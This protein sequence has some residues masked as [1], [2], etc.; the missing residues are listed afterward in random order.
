MAEPTSFFAPPEPQSS[1]SG[2]TPSDPISAAVEAVLVKLFP[3]GDGANAGNIA[4]LRRARAEEF[5]KALPADSKELLE[6]RAKW[7]D[8]EPKVGRF[9]DLEKLYATVAYKETP[10]WKE[11]FEKPLSAAKAEIGE[12]AKEY[13]I[14][15]KEIAA[16]EAMTPK[17]RRAK[18]EKEHGVSLASDMERSFRE[19]ARASK[20]AADEAARLGGEG[21]DVQALLKAVHKH[22]ATAADPGKHVEE[23]ASKLTAKDPKTGLPMDPFFGSKEGQ[24]VIGALKGKPVSTEPADVAALALKGAAYDRIVGEYAKLYA[25]VQ[26]LRRDR[27]RFRTVQPG[28]GTFGGGSGGSQNQGSGGNP[29]EG[30][31][32]QR[33]GTFG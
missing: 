6:L 10:E 14:S 30:I 5:V 25:E 15:E 8:A 27:D 24:E 29:P 32:P 19:Y 20:A 22:Y 3:A 7:Q 26:Q 12:L 31:P 11:N 13:G 1:S 17:D 28:G 21:K 9:A 18:L 16:L 4:E 2:S 33:K 23:V